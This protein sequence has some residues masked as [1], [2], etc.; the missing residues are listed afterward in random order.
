MH[1]LY[2]FQVFLAELAITLVLVFSYLFIYEAR[3]PS[4][5]TPEIQSEIQFKHQD[6]FWNKRILTNVIQYKSGRVISDENLENIKII[7]VNQCKNRRFLMYKCD[8]ASLCGGMGDRQKGIISTFLLSLLTNRT[9]VLDMTKP[10]NVEAGLLPGVYNWSLCKEHIKSLPKKEY[11]KLNLMFGNRSFAKEIENFDFD[12]QWTAKVVLIR[13]NT[14]LIDKISRHNY[15]KT[16]ISWLLDTNIEETIH[17]VL[18]TLFQ[19]NQRILEDFVKLYNNH[20]QGKH[21]VC[22]HIRIGKNPTLPKDN[23]LLRGAPNSTKILGFLKRY[24]DSEKF[25][26]YIATDSDAEKTL[27]QI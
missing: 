3:P 27:N 25:A 5:L 10:C 11:L 14:M 16:R 4:A 13:C 1:S 19:P 7:S 17:K 22:S 26:I 15:T 9:F 21:L 12:N 24:D 8:G 20:V 6:G 18:H 23:R 2:L